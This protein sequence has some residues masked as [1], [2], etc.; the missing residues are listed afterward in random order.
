MVIAMRPKNSVLTSMSSAARRTGVVRE[1]DVMVG[2][3]GRYAAR[4][5]D[6]AS[7]CGIRGCRAAFADAVLLDCGGAPVAS[8]RPAAADQSG[9]GLERNAVAVAHRRCNVS[10]DAQQIPARRTAVV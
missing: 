3:N 1:G 9:L 5:R 6:G 4:D 8:L 7:R 10:G 2:K